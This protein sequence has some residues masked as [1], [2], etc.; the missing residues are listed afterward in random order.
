[1]S[2]FRTVLLPVL[3]C[4]ALLLTGAVGPQSA[5]VAAPAPAPPAHIDPAAAGALDRAIDL[6]DPRQTP[7]LELT[8]WQRVRSDDLS[9]QAQGRYLLAPGRRLRLELQVQVGET[10]GETL[11][12]SDGQV[13]W[14]AN[15]IG[16]NDRTVTK[17]EIGT[18]VED[19]ANPG[20]APQL[21]DVFLQDHCLAGI[22]PLLRG[23]RQR[24]T[25]LRQEAVRWKGRD[26]LLLTG[27][28]P[29][30][31]AG[32]VAGGESFASRQCRLFLDT[33]TAWPHR[34][35]WW[36]PAPEGEA[37]A[38]LLEMEFRNPRLNR[39]LTPEQCAREFTFD[40]GPHEVPDQTRD[41]LELLHRTFRP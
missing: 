8:L 23:L 9:Y 10:Q 17:V 4:A 7:W 25:G 18:V 31:P 38:L 15:R 30:A 20:T 34:I 12:V 16:P 37:S 2:H 11:M 27:S 28:W 14:K 41:E 40:P 32:V 33:A 29:A 22:A 5:P 19:L 13:L 24:M 1:M 26:I 36:G 39:E 35:E 3:A 21:R 6:L